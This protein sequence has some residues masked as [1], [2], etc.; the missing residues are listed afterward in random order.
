M[1]KS[2]SQSRLVC[3]EFPTFRP[4]NTGGPPHG[5]KPET[6]LGHLSHPGEKV[7]YNEDGYPE[8]STY[9]EGN[10]SSGALRRIAHWQPERT[11]EV[12]KGTDY[13]SVWMHT[14]HG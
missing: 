8:K 3:L 10:T 5:L 7:P 9:A 2:G 11:H 13:V 6:Y 4:P 1:L 14:T 12:G